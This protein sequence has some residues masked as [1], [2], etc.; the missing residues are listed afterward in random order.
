MRIGVLGCSIPGAHAAQGLCCCGCRQIHDKGTLSRAT[1]EVQN[2][3]RSTAACSWPSAPLPLTAAWLLAGPTLSPGVLGCTPAGGLGVA[4]VLCW[5]A[6]GAG[7][8]CGLFA[9][10]VL[11]AGEATG[12]AATFGGARRGGGGGGGGREAG[13][14]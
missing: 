5:G 4:L 10:P 12:A 3:G 2:S 1:R 13:A 11:A 7:A 8:A 9:A 6:V 14:A